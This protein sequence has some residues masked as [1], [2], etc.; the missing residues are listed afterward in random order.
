MQRPQFSKSFVGWLEPA[1]NYDDDEEEDDGDDDDGDD[2]DDDDEELSE[3][4]LGKL[5][6]GI[7]TRQFFQT[8]SMYTGFFLLGLYKYFQDPGMI[9]RCM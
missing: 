9:I 4:L 1:Q 5:V 8:Y 7:S 3:K 6:V 2:G